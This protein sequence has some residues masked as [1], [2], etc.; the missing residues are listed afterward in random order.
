[1]PR[2]EKKKTILGVGGSWRKSVKGTF[3]HQ[4]QTKPE[5]LELSLALLLPYPAN[6]Q[7]TTK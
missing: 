6:I 3:E 7:S 5:A 1:M 2:R 4:N